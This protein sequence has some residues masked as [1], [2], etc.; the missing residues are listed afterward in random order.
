MC[1]ACHGQ[2]FEGTQAGPR[3]AGQGYDYLVAAM[4]S[5]ANAQRTNNL[6][7][8]GFMSAL[9]QDQRQAIAHYLSAL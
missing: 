1:K 3:L 5:F 8:P 6:D 2:N 9:T 4:D 7:M